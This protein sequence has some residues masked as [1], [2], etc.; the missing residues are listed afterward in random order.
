[1]NACLLQETAVAR[2]MWA[3]V[4]SSDPLTNEPDRF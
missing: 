2:A 1:M 3:G 4:A